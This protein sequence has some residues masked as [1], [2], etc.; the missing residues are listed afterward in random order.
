MPAPILIALIVA[1]VIFLTLCIAPP[2]IV[3][4]VIKHKKRKKHFDGDSWIFALGEAENIKEVSATRSRLSVSLV[5][6]D[7]IDRELL[8]KLGVSSVLVMST[9][10][11]LLIQDKAEEVANSI[12]KSL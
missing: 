2:I 3:L 5:D 9:K 4:L 10:I 7:R 11:T 12:K 1:I 6:N 8:K